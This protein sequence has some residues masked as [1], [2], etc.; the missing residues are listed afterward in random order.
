[1]DNDMLFCFSF[2]ID[3]FAFDSFLAFLT[4]RQAKR[5]KP[6]SEET[7]AKKRILPK[8]F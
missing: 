4:K 8:Q 5:R 6:T 1:M 3:T 2:C 7:A